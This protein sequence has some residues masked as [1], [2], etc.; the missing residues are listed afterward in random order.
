M[1]SKADR[2]FYII[3]KGKL[4][5]PFHF[6]LFWNPT[7]N[8]LKITLW[9]IP[10]MPQSKHKELSKKSNTFSAKSREWSYKT[11][12]KT[13]RIITKASW[14]APECPQ[15]GLICLHS[16]I[17][18]SLEPTWSNWRALRNQ[19]GLQQIQRHRVEDTRTVTSQP[20]LLLISLQLHFLL[21]QEMMKDQ[22]HV[23][24]CIRLHCNFY[25]YMK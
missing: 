19:S 9:K 7:L 25:S 17:T 11:F 5:I 3:K 18:A 14:S 22:D 4:K 10:G 12:Y 13:S 20:D 16:G 2:A 15:A 23:L 1:K 24:H 6:V 21:L 8:F